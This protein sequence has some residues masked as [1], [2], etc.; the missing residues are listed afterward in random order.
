M[1]FALNML[2]TSLLKIAKQPLVIACPSTAP[3]PQF[4]DLLVPHSSG[5]VV[6]FIV[7]DLS[8]FFITILCSS[9]LWITQQLV[10]SRRWRQGI[11]TASL[12]S[13]LYGLATT[14]MVGLYTLWS[15]AIFVWF[16]QASAIVDQQACAENIVSFEHANV[17][18]AYNSLL[19]TIIWLPSSLIIS[20]ILV[21]A[22][23]EVLKRR[24]KRSNNQSI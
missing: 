3:P 15:D 24:Y 8:L 23:R 1:G 6:T 20:C 7:V 10:A 16:Q 4:G 11:I 19:P 13:A 21:V 2:M 22:V 17:L 14:F 5:G 12:I 9:T 18:A